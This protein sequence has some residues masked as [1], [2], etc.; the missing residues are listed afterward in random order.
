[1]R[2]S[3]YVVRLGSEQMCLLESVVS[4]GGIKSRLQNMQNPFFSMTNHRPSSTHTQT[5]TLVFPFFLGF[6]NSKEINLWSHF[7][8]PILNCCVLSLVD[9]FFTNHKAIIL[10]NDVYFCSRVLT[11]SLKINLEFFSVLGLWGVQPHTMRAP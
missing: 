4:I 8:A 6:I 1:M 11:L 7:C 5:H 3:I 2:F 9:V 10:Y